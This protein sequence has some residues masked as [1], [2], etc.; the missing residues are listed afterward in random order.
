[1]NIFLDNIRKFYY[2]SIE[3]LLIMLICKAAGIKYSG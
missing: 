1:M 3:I 2:N